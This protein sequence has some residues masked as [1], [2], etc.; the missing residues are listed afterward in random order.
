YNPICLAASGNYLF[1][2]TEW[3]ISA[4]DVSDPMNPERVLS[5]EGWDAPAYTYDMEVRDDLLVTLQRI[6]GIWDWDPDAIYCWNISDIRNPQRVFGWRGLPDD[7]R[8]FALQGDYIYVAC[9]GNGLAIVDISDLENPQIVGTYRARW[10]ADDVAVS[11]NYAYVADDLAGLRVIDVSNPEEPNE[12]GFIRPRGAGEGWEQPMTFVKVVGN[13]VYAG[14]AGNGFRLINVADPE[15][16]EELGFYDTPGTVNQLEVR[17]QYVFVA[18]G[19]NFGIY[20]ASEALSI[21]RRELTVNFRAGW[22]IISLNITPDLN[23]FAGGGGYGPD[24]VRMTDQLRID[25]N[26]HHIILMKDER[27]RFYSPAWGYNGIPCWNLEEGYKVKVDEAVETTWEGIAI[28]AQRSVP[29]QRGWNIIPYYPSY[30][31][32]ARPAFNSIVDHLV[33]AK[34]EVGQFYRPYEF[35]FCN[36]I[37]L[38]PSRG[39]QVLVDANVALTYPEAEQGDFFQDRAE[40]RSTCPWTTPITDVNLSLLVKSI[41]GYAASAEDAVVAFNQSGQVVGL[42]NIDPNQ[43]SLCGLAIWGDDPTTEE[44][45]GLQPGEAFELKLWD[46]R[47]QAEIPLKLEQVISGTGLVY[48]PD[49]FSVVEASCVVSLPTDYQ[50]HKPYPNP[51]NAST[52]ISFDLPEAAMVTLA[53]YDVQGRQAAV[54]VRRE[55]AAGSHLVSWNPSNLASGIYLIRMTAPGFS[56]AH[57]VTLVK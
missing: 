47:A 50:L 25:Q 33:L 54:L 28:P 27:G 26:R 9:G 52:R 16:P 2:G 14:E 11:G 10:S 43:A 56:A 37:P 48:E 22:S 49:G 8:K 1:G 21:P 6:R 13:I 41:G 39:Y 17:E 44:K 20:D 46:N 24:I 3:N 4:W 30:E 31:L 55:L 19:I 45:D 57:K 34:N 36:M 29:I 32:E 35:D 23:M 38:S 42:G 53:V 18:D 7:V 15:H 5:M 51:F 12:V 40:R